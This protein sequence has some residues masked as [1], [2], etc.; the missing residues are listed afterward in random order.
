M[1]LKGVLFDFDGVVL[2]SM[3]QHV[4]AW[5]HAFGQQGVKLTEL[6]IY[7]M[8]GMG[9]SAVVNKV[10]DKYKISKEIASKIMKTKSEYYK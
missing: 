9:V 10:C 5:Q 6:D 3:K 2:D 4:I 1:N 8:E 7:L